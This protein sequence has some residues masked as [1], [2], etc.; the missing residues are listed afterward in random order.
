[1]KNIVLVGRGA[2]GSVY[3][4]QLSKT[5]GIKFRVALDLAR[6]ARYESQPFFFNAVQYQFDYFVPSPTE[7][8]V[9]LI[10][11]AT[12]WGG[13]ADALDLIEPMVGPKTLILPLLNGLSAYRVAAERFGEQRVMRGFYIGHT[14]SR[15]DSGQVNQ[16]GTYKTNF[17]ELTNEEPYS[18]RVAN[19]K[20]LFDKADIKYRIPANMLTAQWQK[21]V[22][23]IGTNQ[24]TGLYK[25]SYGELMGSDQAM[26]LSRALMDE[27]QAIAIKL[28]VPR[29]E[30]L[31]SNALKVFE[32]LYS[33]DYSSMAQ[34]TR[35]GRETELDI[36]AGEVIRMGR[37]LSIPTPLNEKF[38]RDLSGRDYLQTL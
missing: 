29:A 33:G 18:D 9:D 14:A 12:K 13:Y 17:G 28:G 3:A 30:E 7:D 21:F 4:V 8:S 32:M 20:A 34:D 19:V 31:S 11:I 37:E 26:E 6:K 16:D 27:A 2:V 24:P 5:P 1:M 35:A 22:M 36:F 25:Y 23:N 38:Y 10:I 15:T